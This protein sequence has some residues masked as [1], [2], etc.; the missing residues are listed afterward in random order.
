MCDTSVST[1]DAIYRDLNV[2]PV[3]A[4]HEQDHDSR[5]ACL[6]WGTLKAGPVKGQTPNLIVTLCLCAG[7][8]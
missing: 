4:G 8:L 1:P 5:M 6:H 3:L 7:C 2:H